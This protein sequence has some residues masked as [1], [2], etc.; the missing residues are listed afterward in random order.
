MILWPFTAIAEEGFCLRAGII[1]MVPALLELEC[2]KYDE[3]QSSCRV[4]NIKKHNDGLSFMVVTIEPTVVD[5]F[6][7]V[8]VIGISKK[9]WYSENV[10]ESYIFVPEIE[11]LT[12]CEKPEKA[13]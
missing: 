8:K 12:K 3:G 6:W 9:I 1:V 2:I 7:K 11:N 10:F 13:Q 4:L 5:L